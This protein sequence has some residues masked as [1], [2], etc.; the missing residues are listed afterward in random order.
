MP[1]G[2]REP[3]PGRGPAYLVA[4]ADPLRSGRMAMALTSAVWPAFLRAS[5]AVRPRLVVNARRNSPSASPF[6][7]RATPLGAA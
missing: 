3:D 5:R 1:E 6:G 4:V 7:C 2:R